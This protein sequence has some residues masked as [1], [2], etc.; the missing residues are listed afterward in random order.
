[1]DMRKYLELFVSEAAEHIEGARNDLAHL[2]E[3]LRSAEAINSLF[4]HFHSIKGM[5]ATMGYGEL[6]QL[7]HAVEDVVDGLRKNGAAL[8]DDLADLV[9]EALD[10]TTEMVDVAAAS[11]DAAPGFSDP[12]SL[13]GRLRAHVPAPSAAARHE[14]RPAAP[15]V[16]AAAPSPAPPAPPPPGTPV[17]RR[18]CLLVIDRQAEFPGA[19]AAMAIGRLKA[20]GRI[21]S[22][23]PSESGMLAA[24]F[25]GE[26]IVEIETAVADTMVRRALGDILDLCRI[27]FL[28]E[29]VPQ[30]DEAPAAPAPTLRIAAGTLDLFLDAIAE[31]IMR[32]G[33]LA[34]A[35]RARDLL[36]A[37][38]VLDKLGE[39]IDRL[40]E[41]VMLIRLL[42]FDHITPRLSLA[43]RDLARRTGK[44]VGLSIDGGDVSLDRSVL[45]EMIDPLNHILRNAVDH[46][47]ESAADRAAL[48]KP[49][50]GS[51][52]IEVS[53]SGDTV[54][55][56]V[57]DDGRGMD[58]EAIRKT[59]LAGG[60]ADRDRLASMDE[61]D[62][63]LLTTIP[64]F[65]TARDVT[66]ISG[67][68]VGMDVVRTRIEALHG[69]MKISS[70]PGRGTRIAMVLPLSVVVIDA[71]LVHAGRSVFAVP[72]RAVARVDLVDPGRIRSTL[73]GRFIA[74]D[75]G[76]GDGP[77]RLVC[78]GESLGA[79]RASLPDGPVPVLAYQVNG[80]RGMLLVDRVLERRELVVRP[81]GPPLERLR[82]YSGAALLDDGRVALVLDLGNIEAAA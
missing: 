11:S 68:G 43:V 16:P 56:A 51:I 24:G 22:T 13:I 54:T 19:R 69:H 31:L 41:Q 2:A 35:L 77:M 80:N 18:R 28:E 82:K 21:L 26:V 49:E 74:P 8:P 6:T 3:G 27:E 75:E 14:E 63:L 58:A 38:G 73:S 53:R 25:D 30:A 70:T 32:R 78:L 66:E 34:E 79:P 62:V 40:R 64:G 65:S 37:G 33:A 29:P 23:S 1:M 52:R 36:T 9:I 45:E 76:A 81:L 67:R 48:G 4:R 59:A 61:E 72:A 60:F 55:I 15:P 44:P 42:P 10:V 17:R 5:A 12:S 46:G 47:I 50:E 57:E 39:S 20:I 7:S 71:F